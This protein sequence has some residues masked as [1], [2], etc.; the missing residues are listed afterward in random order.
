VGLQRARVHSWSP[1]PE[2]L[3]SCDDQRR[4]QAET[5]RRAERE[6]ELSIESAERELMAVRNVLGLVNGGLGIR[7]G[8]NEP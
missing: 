5:G 1:L 3:S 2:S 8:S 7:R 4:L 6:V